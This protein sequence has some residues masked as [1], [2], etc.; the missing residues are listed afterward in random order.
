MSKHPTQ[1]G[2]KKNER[3]SSTKEI[4]RLFS[5]GTA[6]LAFPL[7]VVYYWQEKEVD[8]ISP[9]IA[10][11]LSVS[12]KRFK[13]A[14][15]RNRL[16]RLIK[17]AYRLNKHVLLSSPSLQNKQLRI[18]FMYIHQEKMSFQEVEKSLKKAL[19]LIL[20]KIA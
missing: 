10:I 16:K 14:V 19:E 2:F 18:A 11:L 13:S 8:T 17:E 6:F 3:I 15:D 9:D 7:R 5:E 12:K 1:Y 20:Q 4:E